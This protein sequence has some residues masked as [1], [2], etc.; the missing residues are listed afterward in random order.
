M[1]N[2]VIT[3]V[4]MVT[5][6]GNTLEEVK[7]QYLRG[8][9]VIRPSPSSTEKRRRVSAFLDHDITAG[10]DRVALK[11]LDRSVV[12]GLQAS[13][14]AMADAGLTPGS[15]DAERAGTLIGCGAGATEAMHAGHEQLFLKD[16]VA[17]MALLKILPNAPSSHISMRHGL[18]GESTTYAVACASSATAIGAGLHKIRHGYMDSALVGGVEA[19]L[20]ESTVRGWEALR[21]MARPDPDRPGATCKPFSMNRTGFVLGEGAV[22]FVLEAEEHAKARGA[23]IY[24]TLA[25]YGASA[26]ATHI[27]MPSADGQAKAMR[28]ALREA[29]LAAGDIGYINAHGTAS[30]QGDAVETQSVRQVFGARADLTPMSSTKSIHGHL[31]GASG[32]I[33]LL[34]TLIAL[35]DGIL[36][37]TL[38]LEQPDPV[39]DLD[40]VPH[41]ARTGVRVRAAMCNTFAIGG[42]NASIVLQR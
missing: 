28:A 24:A 36:A 22:L 15:F 32:A 34:A 42:S 33:E 11:M 13:D 37:P 3:G 26:D 29:D 7:A 40:Y 21:L 23:R 10:L 31:L 5:P 38:N 20:G 25:A 4:G 39:C 30:G 8:E 9:S 18:Q 6:M 1:R 27:T 19:P 14:A 35:N 17:A 16:K 2:V 41:Q 12:L